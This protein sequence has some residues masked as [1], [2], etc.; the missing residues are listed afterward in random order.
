[1]ATAEDNGVLYEG[2]DTYVNVVV[3][4]NVLWYIITT[5]AQR[6]TECHKPIYGF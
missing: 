1:M 4:D 5:Q 3:S 2:Q 6:M